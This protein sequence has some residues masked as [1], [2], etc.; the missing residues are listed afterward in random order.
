MIRRVL[1]QR[2]FHFEFLI[3]LKLQGSAKAVYTCVTD[4]TGIG[5]L[6]DGK[7]G[8]FISVCE[9]VIRNLFFSLGK[10]IVGRLYL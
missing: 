3:A 10:L 1:A 5:K 9:T 7:V 8:N 4:L 6:G 2:K